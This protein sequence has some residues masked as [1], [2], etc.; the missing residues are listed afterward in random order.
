M[1]ARIIQNLMILLLLTGVSS[2]NW[3]RIVDELVSNDMLE[4]EANRNEKDKTQIETRR[5]GFSLVVG[6]KTAGKNEGS[7]KNEGREKKP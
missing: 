3:S 6:H 5:R 1:A 7:S 4:M 2:L